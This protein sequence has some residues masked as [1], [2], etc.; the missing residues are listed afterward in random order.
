VRRFAVVGAV[1]LLIAVGTPA[2]VAAEEPVNQFRFTRQSSYRSD[3]TFASPALAE[4]VRFRAG[5]GTVS[6]ECAINFGWLP[7][8]AYDIRAHEIALEG[9]I[10]GFAWELS[11]RQCYDGTF[12][13]DLLIHSE[14]SADGGQ[15][16]TWESHVWTEADPADYTSFGCI[17]VSYED[18][19][20]LQA[21][22]QQAETSGYRA[23]L[24]VV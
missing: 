7:R 6:D 13:T 11:E 23:E 21:T 20:V 14:M 12:R 16:D 19:L 3:L 18:V 24:L 2:R 17:K 4:P 8:G 10:A 22:Y 5:S 1:L 9:E 15:D